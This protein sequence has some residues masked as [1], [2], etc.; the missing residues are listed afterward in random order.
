MFDRLEEEFLWDGGEDIWPKYLGDDMVLLLDTMKF[1]MMMETTT[2]SS[3]LTGLMPLKSLSV[4]V[5]GGRL[6]CSGLLKTLMSMS[7]MAWR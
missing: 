5:I 6:R 2:G 3:W 1:V 7:W 4:K